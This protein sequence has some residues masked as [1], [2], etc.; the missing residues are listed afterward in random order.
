MR[1]RR[2][3]KRHRLTRSVAGAQG[4][5]EDGRPGRRDNTCVIGVKSL[6]WNEKAIFVNPMAILMN[7]AGAATRRRPQA[8]GPISSTGRVGPNPGGGATGR[9]AF[10]PSGLRRGPGAMGGPRPAEPAGPGS[11]AGTGR[12]RRA[13]GE[14]SAAGRR[15]TLR[16]EGR[17]QV[18]DPSAARGRAAEGRVG[19][20]HAFDLARAPGL[21]EEGLQRAVEPQDGEPALLRIG[22]DPVAAPDALGLFRREP[23]RGRAVLGGLRRR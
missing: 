15:A 11:R 7:G 1:D 9:G 20:A 21:G 4:S 5:G 6:I 19:S 16:P 12:E 8:R 17:G 23:D 13:R 18:A 10:L 22:L 3:D 14:T 2:P